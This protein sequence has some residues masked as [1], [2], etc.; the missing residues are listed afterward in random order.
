MKAMKPPVES[1]RGKYR[2]VLAANQPIIEAKKED[3]P[4]YV[5]QSIYIENVED[6]KD[7]FIAIGSV[8]NKI[9]GTDQF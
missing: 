7:L 9:Y 2:V 6:L 1:I 5:R 8:L 4:Y 3:S